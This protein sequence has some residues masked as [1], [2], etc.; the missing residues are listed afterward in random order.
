MAK[1][2][3]GPAFNPPA[4]VPEDRGA[5]YG[6]LICCLGECQEI[7]QAA[8]GEIRGQIADQ[9][10]G[11]AVL[12]Q[13]I[14][15]PIHQAVLVQLQG[16][17][18][19]VGLVTEQ[20]GDRVLH[21]LMGA[22][23]LIQS[24]TEALPAVA[25]SSDQQAATPPTTPPAASGGV[26]GAS[27]STGQ[28]AASLVTATASPPGPVGSP[29]PSPATTRPTAGTAQI[30][31]AAV[32]PPAARPLVPMPPQVLTRP[33]PATSSAALP[34]YSVDVGAVCPPAVAGGAFPVDLDQP[35][36]F[37][38]SPVADPWRAKALLWLGLDPAALE[39][40]ATLQQWQQA[41]L[42][43]YLPDHLSVAT[44]EVRGSNAA[45]SDEGA[46]DATLAGQ[47][48]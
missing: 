2:N 39:G 30:G 43:G 29:P 34:S 37:L 40:Y 47:F 25:G 36:A 45:E 27:L 20:L 22:A 42:Y 19:N 4:P 46:A 24:L 11:A 6:E 44:P 23:Y 7:Y 8:V 3:R 28:A 18:D 10:R 31:G 9:L 33:S 15:H 17:A 48:R 38:W 5:L 26:S 21:N 1:R 13:R 16:G 14:L 32:A 41:V 12:L 35:L